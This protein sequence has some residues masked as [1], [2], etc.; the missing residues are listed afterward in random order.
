MTKWS[1]L[2]LQCVT[3]SYLG[4][5]TVFLARMLLTVLVIKGSSKAPGETRKCV[6]NAKKHLQSIK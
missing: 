6:K 1:K 3:K 5:V 2:Y 4:T